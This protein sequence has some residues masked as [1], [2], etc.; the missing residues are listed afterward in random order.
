MVDCPLNQLIYNRTFYINKLTNEP[1]E[2][3]LLFSICSYRACDGIFDKN[4]LNCYAISPGNFSLRGI[5]F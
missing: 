1:K 5:R 3:Y 4:Y 2:N